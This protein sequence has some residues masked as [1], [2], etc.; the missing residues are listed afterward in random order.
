MSHLKFLILI[1]FDNFVLLKLV[2]LFDRKL[3]SGYQKLD[4]IDPFFWHFLMN[5]CPLKM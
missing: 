4:K 5:F 2:T 1:F 3:H